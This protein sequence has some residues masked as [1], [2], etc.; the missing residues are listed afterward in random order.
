M[1]QDVAMATK[2]LLAVDWT[3]G[4]P[5]VARTMVFRYTLNAKKRGWFDEVRSSSGDRRR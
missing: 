3:S 4:D 2:E 5:E 1:D